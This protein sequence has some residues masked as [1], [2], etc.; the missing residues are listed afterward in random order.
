MEGII[1]RDLLIENQDA[2]AKLFVDALRPKPAPEVKDTWIDGR[3]QF[4]RVKDTKV[5]KVGDET[6]LS[7]KLTELKQQGVKVVDFKRQNAD[8]VI[9]TMAPREEVPNDE[10]L[11]DALNFLVDSTT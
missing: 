4:F 5:E 2:S 8:W 10:D 6:A 11:A 7:K 9:Q 1:D 3:Y